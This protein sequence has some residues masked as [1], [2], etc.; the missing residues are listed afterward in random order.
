MVY[1]KLSDITDPSSSRLW[2]L[3]EEHPDSI[4]DVV[5]VVDCQSRNERARLISVPAN[6]HDGATTFAFADGHSEAH[7][8][9]LPPT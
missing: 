5:F 7:R 4:D 1:R 8:F 6:Y 2:L 9:L 3:V